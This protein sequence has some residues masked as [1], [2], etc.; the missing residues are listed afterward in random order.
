MVP[1]LTD[2]GRQG[3][4]VNRR[5]LTAPVSPVLRLLVCDTLAR[6]SPVSSLPP[7]R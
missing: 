2:Q 4:K 6:A 3:F 5:L 7:S 1:R